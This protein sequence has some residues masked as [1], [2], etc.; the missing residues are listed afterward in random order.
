MST[1]VIELELFRDSDGL[2]SKNNVFVTT[3]L[4]KIV[5]L[6]TILNNDVVNL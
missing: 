2:V 6:G 3:K 5:K 4:L 1:L